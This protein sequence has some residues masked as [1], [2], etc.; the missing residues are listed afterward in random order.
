MP[1][2]NGMKGDM[3]FPGKNT[4]CAACRQRIVCNVGSCG[5][6][7]L[8]THG[9]LAGEDCNLSTRYYKCPALCYQ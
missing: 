5:L 7:I 3:G 4:V 6:L 2:D 1:G 8:Y 9:A